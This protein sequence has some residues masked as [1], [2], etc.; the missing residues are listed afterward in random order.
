M[1]TEHTAY[2][3]TLAHVN[4]GNCDEYWG[5]S[6]ITEADL[7]DTEWSCPHCSH[8]QPISELVEADSESHE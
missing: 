2:I 4:C 5:L 1:V 3:E 7:T 8:R 6:D